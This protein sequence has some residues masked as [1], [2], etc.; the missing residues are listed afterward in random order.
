VWRQIAQQLFGIAADAITVNLAEF[1]LTFRVE[2][3][4]TAQCEARAFGHHTKAATDGASRVAGHRLSN[5]AD[6]VGRVMPGFVGEMRVRRD[7]IDF[8]PQCL[9]RVIVICEITQFSWTN[10][11][12][13]GQVEKHDGP[14][15][16]QIGITDRKKF[17][18]VISRGIERLNTG[19]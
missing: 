2:D 10:E 17:A 9:E 4:T 18:I 6:G 12:E 15:A 5:L 19:V 13:V 1:D 16:F 3:G 11:G 8:H 14:L 7:S